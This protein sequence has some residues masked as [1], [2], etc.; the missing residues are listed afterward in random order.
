MQISTAKGFKIPSFASLH[1]FGLS[2]TFQWKIKYKPLERNTGNSC[3]MANDNRV[4]THR[5]RR[6][7]L[8]RMGHTN[9]M[10]TTQYFQQTSRISFKHI[11]NQYNR[12]EKHTTLLLQLKQQMLLYKKPV[13]SKLKVKER[14]LERMKYLSIDISSHRNK[15]EK[16]N[17]KPL[18]KHRYQDSYETN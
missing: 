4:A 12:T 15:K 3:K 1:F 8:Y 14:I 5:T 13:S 9:L 2:V 18:K 17:L 7:T 16:Y 6:V 10:R 11:P